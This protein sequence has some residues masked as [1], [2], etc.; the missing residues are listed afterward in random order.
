MCLTF[1]VDDPWVDKI[2]SPG[3]WQSLGKTEP[4]FGNLM[5]REAGMRLKLDFFVETIDEFD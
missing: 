1:S 4:V 2:F 3:L 5:T